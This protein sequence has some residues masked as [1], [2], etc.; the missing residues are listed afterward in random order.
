MNGEKDALLPTPP[1]ENA[2]LVAN[3]KFVALPSDDTTSQLEAWTPSLTLPLESLSASSSPPALEDGD[4]TLGMD[5]TYTDALDRSNLHFRMSDRLSAF[6][7]RMDSPV[8]SSSNEAE[9]GG[10]DNDASSPHYRKAILKPAT[11]G[12]QTSMEDSDMNWDLDTEVKEPESLV[13]QEY[14]DYSRIRNLRNGLPSP[15]PEDPDIDL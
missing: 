10:S 3:D 12:P 14:R 13:D 9:D 15:E 2:T 5:S 4:P 6:H 7:D 1:D 11:F 8:S